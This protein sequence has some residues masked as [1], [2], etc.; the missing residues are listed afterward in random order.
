MYLGLFLIN[1]NIF[2]ISESIW[3]ERFTLANNRASKG[4]IRVFNILIFIFS[5]LEGAISSMVSSLA[6]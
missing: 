1:F 5:I 4:L 2:N 6:I 3:L